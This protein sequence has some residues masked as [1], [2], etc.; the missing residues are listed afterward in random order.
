MNVAY[1]NLHERNLSESDGMTF[2]NREHPLIFTHFS[3]FNPQKPHHLC[4]PLFFNRFDST[5]Q[6]VFTRL[7]HQY[8]ERLLEN[9]YS[10]LSRIPSSWL[11]GPKLVTAKFREA[12]DPFV[13]IQ[14]A[15]VYW[16]ARM[17]VK[18][19]RRLWRLALLFVSDTK[20]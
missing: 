17:P 5:E 2:V 1:W 18:L 11:S 13:K 15:L 19:R 3:G 8:A 20:Y 12:R 16:M 10:Q 14:Y 7:S 4:D 6:P 9:H